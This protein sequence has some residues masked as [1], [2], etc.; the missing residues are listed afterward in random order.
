[1]KK[2]ALFL[3]VLAGLS[4]CRSY[5]MSTLSSSNTAKIDS[6]GV[7]RLENDSLIIS[8]NFRGDNSPLNVEIF[9][10][11][12][13]PVYVSWDQSSLII[14]D[15]AYSYA[16]D[17]I[18]IDGSASGISTQYSRRGPAFTDGTISATAKLPKNESFLPPHA[19]T[20]RTT[21]ILDQVGIASIDP[22]LFKKKKSILSSGEGE[23]SIKQADFSSENSPLRFKSYITLYTLKDNQPRS[24]AL[25]Q[26]FF[27]SSVIKSAT[28]PKNFADYSYSPG[29]VMIN[30]KTTGYGKTAA[31]VGLVTAAGALGVADAAINNKENHK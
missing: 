13:E 25:Q 23:I 29:N 20:D 10:K 16:E 24:F 28:N 19:K 14:N 21:R 7:F 26:D 2:I 15:K 12:N 9:N 11:L 27:I 4:S 6:T 18:K 1:M 17:E 31:I 3:V 30:S 22:S 8:Y 5:Q